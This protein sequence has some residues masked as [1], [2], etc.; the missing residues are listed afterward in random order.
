MGRIKAALTLVAFKKLIKIPGLHAVG[1]APGLYLNV[2]MNPKSA[3]GS[4]PLSCSWIYRYTSNGRRR[5]MGLGNLHDLTLES[6]R[7]RANELR[8]K[9]RQGI[10]P[11]DH[12]RQLKT[13]N[14]K[15]VVKSITFQ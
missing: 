12:K 5:D 11:I 3:M 6:A 10:D 8:G 4:N 9:V 15:A 2:N 13:A 1:G 14:K 7:I